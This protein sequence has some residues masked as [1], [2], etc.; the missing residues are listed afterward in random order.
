MKWTSIFCDL[1]SITGLLETTVKV[2]VL[3]I[4]ICTEIA[5]TK[6]S[7]GEVASLMSLKPVRCQRPT[8]EVQTAIRTLVEFNVAKFLE[9]PGI[10]TEWKNFCVRASRDR[11]L[12]LSSSMI[13]NSISSTELMNISLGYELQLDS[14]QLQTILSSC[15]ATT[16]AT[17]WIG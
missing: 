1:R 12:V 16:Y 6:H 13:S 9:M 8:W 2:P 15:K 4:A 14:Q 5:E 3:V 10:F 11:F 7:S 17:Y